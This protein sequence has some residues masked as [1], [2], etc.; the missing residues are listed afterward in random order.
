MDSSKDSAG[1]TSGAKSLRSL[2]EE[3]D[4]HAKARAPASTLKDNGSALIA[5]ARVT[6]KAKDGSG[7]KGKQPHGFCWEK[8]GP[9]IAGAELVDK[10]EGIL[11]IAKDGKSELAYSVKP[12]GHLWFEFALKQE[13]GSPELSIGFSVHVS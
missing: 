8:S 5:T 2:Y 12:G 7:G 10:E 4:A 1:G 13:G 11:S 3:M 6:P 9:E